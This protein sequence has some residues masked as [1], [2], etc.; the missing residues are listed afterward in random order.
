MYRLYKAL[1]ISVL[2]LGI[3]GCGP[4]IL[5]GGAT[6]AKVVHDRRTTGT[7]VEDQAIEFKAY[8]TLLGARS[9]LGG[10][11]ITVTSYN[12]VVLLSGEVDSEQI[13]QWAEDIVR[14][15]DQVRFIHNELAIGPKSAWSSRSN[16]AWLTT[17]VKS[18]LI[19]VDGISGFDP[20]RVKVVTER[21]II[22]LFG[23]VTPQ[24]G[25]AV[26]GVVSR[27][28]GVQQVVKLFEYI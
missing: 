3:S 8:R 28:A 23:L 25:E 17:K 13:R 16:D 26:T 18:S 7:L 19:Q 4:T 24:E 12:N 9:N 22:Y 20:T 6:A 11:N 1:L 27:L 21:G 2:L 15:I 14:N 5:L 10:S